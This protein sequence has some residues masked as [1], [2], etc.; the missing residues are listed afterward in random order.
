MH[1]LQSKGFSADLHFSSSPSASRHFVSAVFI[2]SFPSYLSFSELSSAL[3]LY[4]S[5]SSMKLLG[6]LTGLSQLLGLWNVQNAHAPINFFWITDESAISP[7]LSPV[8]FLSLINLRLCLTQVFWVG[9][10]SW[11]VSN[12]LQIMICV[13]LSGVGKEDS[14]HSTWQLRILKLHNRKY[15]TWL[16][17]GM[18]SFTQFIFSEV[19]NFI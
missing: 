4:C 1:R 12:K 6:L 15:C 8:P 11:T 5:R 7:P 16:R 14:P 18:Q 19:L 3:S 17:Y 13:G 10:V 2:C 9:V